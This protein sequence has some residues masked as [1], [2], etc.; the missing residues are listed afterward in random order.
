MMLKSKIKEEVV[1]QFKY[2][3]MLARSTLLKFYLATNEDNVLWGKE[4]NITKTKTDYNKG[5]KAYFLFS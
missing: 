2:I 4:K 3:F 5:E 1:W